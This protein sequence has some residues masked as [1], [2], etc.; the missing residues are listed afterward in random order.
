[1]TINNSILRMSSKQFKIWKKSKIKRKLLSIR[2]CVSLAIKIKIINSHRKDPFKWFI[3]YL[4][5]KSS[6]LAVYQKET[7]NEPEIPEIKYFF[8]P[9]QFLEI[10]NIYLQIFRKKVY[11][12]EDEKFERYIFTKEKSHKLKE[13]TSKMEKKDCLEFVYIPN[14]E[15]TLLQLIEEWEDKEF[16]LIP[17]HSLDVLT[18]IKRFRNS[19]FKQEYLATWM[20]MEEIFPRI[21]C[22]TSMVYDNQ[23]SKN[24]YEVWRNNT[25]IQEYFSKEELSHLEL[26]LT[27]FR[28][29]IRRFSNN[30][31]KI[32]DLLEYCPLNDFNDI[33]WYSTQLIIL[34]RA[35]VRV[36]YII[37]GNNYSSSN[38][39]IEGKPDYYHEKEKDHKDWLTSVLIHRNLLTMPLKII[40]EGKTESD[41]LNEY[42]KVHWQDKWVAIIKEGGIDETPNYERIFLSLDFDYYW[43]L[44]DYDNGQHEEKYEKIK[45]KTWFFPDFVTE[46]FTEEQV[47]R[48]YNDVIASLDLDFKKYFNEEKILEDLNDIKKGS[49]K[50]IEEIPNIQ[51]TCIGYE[52]YLTRL[53]FDKIEI[54]RKIFSKFDKFRTPYNDLLNKVKKKLKNKFKKEYGKCLLGYFIEFNEKRAIRNEIFDKKM[55]D[56]FSFFN[57]ITNRQ[58]KSFLNR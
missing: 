53:S 52:D 7:K 29:T 54:R 5:E 14:Y 23:D 57:S 47:L 46:I 9:L 6:F 33:L 35:L 2:D 1:M 25:N 19:S 32:S 16:Q 51:S 40:V 37:T 38:R 20:K 11:Y 26:F 10:I 36:L 39:I 15:E 34:E 50:M 21:Q 18:N 4:I 48:A 3:H 17:S 55:E 42:K 22:L 31:E 44:F 27:Y 58:F 13:L 12:S 49:N 24:S 28:E 43:Y 56:N 45:N 8:H 30:I 41:L